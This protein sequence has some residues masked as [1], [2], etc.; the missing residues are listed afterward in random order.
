MRLVVLIITLSLFFGCSLKESDP[1][2]YVEMYIFLELDSSYPSDPY[3]SVTETVDLNKYSRRP[4]IFSAL[5]IDNNNN[6]VNSKGVSTLDWLDEDEESGILYASY[7][8]YIGYDTNYVKGRYRF[9]IIIDWDL[10]GDLTAGDMVLSSYTIFADK[11][12]NPETPSVKVEDSEY[13]SYIIYD[14]SDYS[15]IID[16]PLTSDTGT[17]WTITHISQGSLAVY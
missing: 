5:G 12:G 14:S 6:S 17:P 7:K 2:C 1:S 8:M 11:D 9:Q 16:N 15:L 4:V 10:S 3:Y 13:G